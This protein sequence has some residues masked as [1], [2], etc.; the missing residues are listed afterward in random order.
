MLPKQ[1][2]A[3]WYW[4]ATIPFLSIGIMGETNGLF[5]VALITLLQTGHFYIRETFKFS[6]PTQVRVGFLCW[7]CCG[8]LPYMEWMLWVQLMGTSL[9]VL[10]DYCA[11][12]RLMTLAPWNR[13][14][15]LN[16]RLVVRT[17]F[18]RPVRGSILNATGVT[19]G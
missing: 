18:S 2:L 12:A 16:P 17:F 4:L 10:F 14:Q 15:P 13:T 8:L 3:W 9:S 6:F 7:F 1:D 11:M 19:H 5:I